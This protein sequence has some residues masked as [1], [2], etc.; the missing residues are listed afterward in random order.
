MSTHVH[1]NPTRLSILLIPRSRYWVFTSPIL[2]LLYNELSK[3]EDHN[4]S[5]NDSDDSDDDAASSSDSL[6]RSSTL[7]PSTNSSS[8][9]H[10]TF[11]STS[12][13]NGMAKAVD[14]SSKTLSNDDYDHASS[15]AAVLSHSRHNSQASASLSDTEDTEND[16]YFFHIAFTPSECTVICSS[17]L[18][19]SLFSEPILFCHQLGLGVEL[20]EEN[21][22]SLQVDTDSG[23][24]TDLILELTKPLSENQISLFF[25]SSHFN[26]IVL[27]PYSFRE[28]VI[29]ILTKSNF[30]FTNANSFVGG[31][32]DTPKPEVVESPDLETATFRLFENANIKPVINQDVKLLLT[33]ARSGEV[34]ATILKAAKVLTSTEFIPSYFAI[35]RTSINE[36][37]LILPKSSKKRSR[38]GFDSKSIIGSAQD[39]IIPITIDFQKLPLDSTGI[40]AGVA[41]RLINGFTQYKDEDYV[42]EMNY[43]S[44]AK[45]G[46]IMI[47]EENVKI[48]GTMLK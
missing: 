25:L 41:S 17:S 7:S 9:S 47:P 22:L 13:K 10:P 40:V 44:M 39:I 4:D 16:D 5:D 20:L 11:S 14:N 21:F 31:F 27:V 19:D 32:D 23:F 24:D 30:T 1:L 38:M 15:S 43:L 36:V 29:H 12:D 2:Q 45:L 28:K 42:F 26:D 3:T 37:S 6:S 46:I 34:N 33:G 48:I 8:N 18:M 35:T